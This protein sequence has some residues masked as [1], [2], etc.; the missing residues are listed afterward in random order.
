MGQLQVGSY[1]LEQDTVNFF[2]KGPDNIFF[3]LSYHFL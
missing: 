1:G 3:S 2:C